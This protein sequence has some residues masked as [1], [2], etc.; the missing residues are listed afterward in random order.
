MHMVLENM[1]MI[2]A[3]YLVEREKHFNTF[4]ILII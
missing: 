4:Q 1:R 3:V 2:W